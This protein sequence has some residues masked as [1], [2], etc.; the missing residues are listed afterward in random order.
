MRPALTF[1]R[2]LAFLLALFASAWLHA[3]VLFFAAPPPLSRPEVR[4]EVQLH[5][6]PAF[7]ADDAARTPEPPPS[8]PSAGD[9]RSGGAPDVTPATPMAPS[10]PSRA[11]G[12]STSSFRERLRQKE[13]AHQSH[14]AQRAARLAVLEQTVANEPSPP[15]AEVFFCGARTLGPKVRLRAERDVSAYVGVFPTG[16]FPSA[17]VAQMREVSPRGIREKAQHWF[18]LPQEVLP[19][20][21]DAPAGALIAA[22][23]AD[24]RCLVGVHFD[25]ARFFP[26]RFSRIPVRIVDT[27]DRVRTA[28]VDVALYDDA[29]FR[30]TWREGDP[31]PFVS[32]ALYDHATVGRNLREHYAAARAL[33]DLAGFL[34]GLGR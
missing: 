15:S 25:P 9:A 11:R 30:L 2:R 28:L 7:E 22:G 21:L 1:E 10:I 8:P 5:E 27:D 26:L 17:Y 14:L 12:Q 23:R 32:G 29:T 13:R 34:G 20:G 4:L 6:T 31:L 16:L 3:T 18:V 33:R 19:L 24:A